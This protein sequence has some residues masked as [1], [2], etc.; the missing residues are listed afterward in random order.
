MNESTARAERFD[1]TAA[2]QPTYTWTVSQKPLAVCFPLDI[3]DR[4]EHEAV[5]SFR[6][7][8]SRGSEVGGVLFGTVE[9]GSPSMVTVVSYDP[10]VC[11]YT[12][13]PLYRLSDIDILRFTKVMEAGVRSGMSPVGFYRSH[14]RKGL[15]MDA[16]DVAL[17]D[18]KFPAS[19]GIALLIRPFASK[20]SLG[21]VFFRED[22][23]VRTES[24]G[25]VFPFRTSELAGRLGAARIRTGHGASGA[26][27]AP[28]SQGDAPGADRAH[29]LAAR[30]RHAPSAPSG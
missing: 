29:R 28:G 4:L 1:V 8:S 9:P 17:L 18:S 13:G 7:L 2:S 25:P 19:H 23:S 5:E 21:G 30:N 27:P 12:R 10:V 15:S 11:D 3:I 16:D 24:S 22:G 26:S 14:T 20:P 6:S